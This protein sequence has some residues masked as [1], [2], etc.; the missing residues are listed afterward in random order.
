MASNSKS[1]GFDR[2]SE[3]NIYVCLFVSRNKDNKDVP[4]FI[5]RRKSFLTT[6]GY[7]DPVLYN[8]FEHFLSDG[9][10]GEFCRMYYSVN[11]RNPQ[12]IYKHLLHFLIDEP[13]FNLC[14]LSSKIAGIAAQKECA[15]EKK[16]MFDFDYND[17]VKANE[18][19]Q[20]IVAIDDSIEIDVHKTPNG[21]AIITNHGFDTRELFKKWA[22]NV[23][24]KKD[25]LLCVHWLFDIDERM[26][27]D[28]RK[29]FNDI[30]NDSNT[31]TNN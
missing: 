13:N 19:C 24:L 4:N 20:D 11:A 18:F 14:A 6:K 23:T 21:Y 12:S 16:W 2:D 9:V 28:Q 25:D 29:Y 1:W 5:E 26:D 10:K 31:A 3:K 7:N 22:E 27:L 30:R 8:E 17:K 15:L